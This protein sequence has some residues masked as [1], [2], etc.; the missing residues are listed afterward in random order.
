MRRRSPGPPPRRPP[1]LRPS[2][3]HLVGQRL[4]HGRLVREVLVQGR[5]RDAHPVRQPAHGERLGALRLQQRACRGDDLPGPAGRWGG[6]EVSHA[7]DLPWYGVATRPVAEDVIVRDTDKPVA[8]GRR[9]GV[10][11]GAGPGA[12]GPGSRGCEQHLRGAEVGPGE[13]GPQPFAQGQRGGGLDPGD[14][15]GVLDVD[16]ADAGLAV[17]DVDHVP[18]EDLA[19]PVPEQRRLDEI[20]AR[21]LH[22]VGAAGALGH[23]RGQAGQRPEHPLRGSR[24]A[25][26]A[27]HSSAA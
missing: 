23:L 21:A 8:G 3:E 20:D 2:P 1:G 18:V 12:G 19:D 17:L 7:G 14:D 13:A 16:G 26:A 25:V 6:G 27:R 10:H 24:S 5:C 4:H 11:A 15:R 22:G 9:T